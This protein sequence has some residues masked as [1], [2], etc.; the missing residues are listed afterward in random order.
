MVRVLVPATVDEL[1][2]FIQFGSRDKLRE[3]YL[4]PL[5]KDGLIELTIK[6]KPKAPNQKYIIM[7]V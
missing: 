4:N 2:E 1:M 6:D 7:I 5:R 3:L